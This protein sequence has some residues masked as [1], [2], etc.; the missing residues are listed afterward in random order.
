MKKL[1][2]IN[3]V[4]LIG[5]ISYLLINS[6][7]AFNSEKE[8]YIITGELHQNF[9]YTK[10]L[11]IEFTE[12]KTEKE[13]E[14]ERFTENLQILELKIKN[15]NYSE[16]ELYEYQLGVNKLQKLRYEFDV[17]MNE[18]NAELNLKIW[19]KL[20]IYINEYG[21]ENNFTIIYGADGNGNIL[22][23]EEELNITKDVIDYCNQKYNGK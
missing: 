23:A 5:I 8:A 20:N 13:K 12:V 10:E 4:L 1:P 19:E 22:Y 21:A 2:I 17:Y 18:L 6:F 15:E 11:N 7:G 9:D 16:S 14:I 3:T